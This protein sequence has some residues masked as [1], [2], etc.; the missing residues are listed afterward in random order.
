[1]TSVVA[2]FESDPFA[3]L[4]PS[5]VVES[6]LFCAVPLPPGPAIER[7]SGVAWPGGHF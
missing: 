1:V 7:Y 5:L 6:D 2:P 3:R 4:F